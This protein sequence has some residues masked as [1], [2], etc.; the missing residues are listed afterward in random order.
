MQS[1]QNSQTSQGYIFQ[2]LQYF[3]NKLH[4]FTKFRMLFPAA[5]MNIPSSK[6]CLKGEWS[7]GKE[8][9]GYDRSLTTIFSQ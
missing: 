6:L 5:L 4:N 7:I 1:I 9:S 3:E 2:I 8:G